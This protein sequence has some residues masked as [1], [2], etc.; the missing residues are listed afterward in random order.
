MP[1]YYKYIEV[2]RIGD[3]TTRVAATTKE[4]MESVKRGFKEAITFCTVTKGS[5]KKK[6]VTKGKTK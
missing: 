5:G 1:S 6:K 3:Q 4:E 2:I